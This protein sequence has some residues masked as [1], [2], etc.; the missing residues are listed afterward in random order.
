MIFG[1]SNAIL[2]LCNAFYKLYIIMR[3]LAS[4]ILHINGALH[5]KYVV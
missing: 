3:K 5:S 4:A 2:A 1:Q